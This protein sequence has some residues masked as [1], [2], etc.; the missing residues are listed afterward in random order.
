MWQGQAL[1]FAH[2]PGIYIDH[3]L[4]LTNTNLLYRWCHPCMVA[5]KTSTRCIHHEEGAQSPCTDRVWKERGRVV[6]IDDQL[7]EI[8]GKWN[9]SCF[10][11]LF[12]N[13]RTYSNC[14][15]T[16]LN[17]LSNLDYVTTRSRSEP[18]DMRKVII[19]NILILLSTQGFWRSRRRSTR[20]LLERMV[21]IA[22]LWVEQKAFLLRSQV[23]L[24]YKF[25]WFFKVMGNKLCILHAPIFNEAS[26]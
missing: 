13:G 24:L 7:L 23:M 15:A 21:H 2:A 26:E 18:C 3:L 16:V 19:H 14:W 25:I 5:F 20:C 12:W 17:L 1:F 11:I 22:H 9:Y 8:W 6:T 10:F 4:I